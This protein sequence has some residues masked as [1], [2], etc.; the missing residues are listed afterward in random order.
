M[1]I[2]TVLPKITVW[3]A[4]GLWAHL[5]CIKCNELIIKGK[6]IHRCSQ[7]GGG[8]QRGPITPPKI[9]KIRFFLQKIANFLYFAVKNPVWGLT[10]A[11]QG[12][13]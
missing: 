12:Q 7:Q 4:Y 9:P 11:I 10:A 5:C 1:E 13:E 2:C 8:G 6:C 3:S